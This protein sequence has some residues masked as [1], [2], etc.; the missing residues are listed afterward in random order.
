MLNQNFDVV[1]EKNKVMLF[2]EN[3]NYLPILL[4]II[5]QLIIGVSYVAGQ[6]C[7]MIANAIY[8]A[9]SIALQRPKADMMRDLCLMLFTAALI[10]ISLIGSL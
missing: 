1:A 4:T 7:W 9:R 8:I 5:G 2:W 6:S 10:V 3:L